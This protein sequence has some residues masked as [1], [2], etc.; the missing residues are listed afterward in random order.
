MKMK[1]F[2]VPY[3]ITSIIALTLL[4]FFVIS[5][6]YLVKANTVDTETSSETPPTIEIAPTKILFIGN[7]SR[8][9]HCRK[10][11]KLAASFI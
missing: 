2:R 6:D 5:T 8:G 7:S 3:I 4:S 11:P 1:N 9:I 10:C